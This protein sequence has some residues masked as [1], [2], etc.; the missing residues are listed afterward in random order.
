MYSGTPRKS[1]LIREVS[2]FQ[3]RKS[4]GV[5]QSVLI[6]QNVLMCPHLGVPLYIS[7][8]EIPSVG[9]P[10]ALHPYLTPQASVVTAGNELCAYTEVLHPIP[11]P[12]GGHTMI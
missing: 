6:K 8:C 3:G 9:P 11:A 4:I 2:R 7:P 12:F 1:V 10:S 5:K